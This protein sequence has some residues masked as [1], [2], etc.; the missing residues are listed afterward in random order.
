M[1][2]TIRKHS[3]WLWWVIAALTIISF[4][5]WNIAPANRNGGVG[6][7]GTYGT[8][9]GHKI[10]RQEYIN[11]RNEF[12]LFYW[13]RNDEWPDHN[14]NLKDKDLDEQIYLR[15]MLT[16]K[17]GA[18]GIYVSEEAAAKTAGEM[19][20]S[21]ELARAFGLTGQAVPFQTFVKMLTSEGLTAADFE[22]FARNDLIIQQLVQTLGLNGSLI[23]P[24]EATA[25]YQRMHQDV[26]AQVV[27]FLASNYLSQVAVTPP[28]VA[29]FFTNYMPQYR[30]PDRV[31]VNYVEFNL[32]NFLAQ[33]KTE[34]AKTNLD[35]NVNAAF[36]KY[37]MDAFPEAKTPDEAKAKIRDLLIHQRALA[38]AQR[39]ANDFANAVVNQTPQRPENLAA[40]AKQMGLTVRL[41]A[42]FSSPYGPE[43]FTAPAAFT[44][45]AFALTPDDPFAG[46]IAG[47]YAYYEIALDKKLPSEIPP[48]DQIRDRVTQDYRMVQATMLAQRAGSNSAPVLAVQSAAGHNFASACIAAGLHPESLPPFSLSTQELPELAGRASLPQIQNAAFGTPV[49]QTSGFQETEDGGFII[50]VQSRLP[51]DST[52]MNADLPQFTA[53]LRRERASEAFNQWLQAEA[54]RQLRNTP[55]FSQQAVAGAK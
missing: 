28:V 39:Q 11:A 47:A 12:Y 48:L 5:G 45:S 40:V 50:Y 34:W 35:E 24:Q 53:S 18:L 46:P 6:G 10:T 4:I 2:G 51:V 20:R 44:K 26:S 8:L 49:G 31:Q 33:S 7:N 22:R 19:L 29:Q 25:A 3:K 23:T 30:L 14:P 17:A 21:P 52:A 1:I 16:Q 54:N 13:F 55:V 27:F 43:E 9:Y 32:T 42:P 38:D 15:L 37:G 41:T 36:Q